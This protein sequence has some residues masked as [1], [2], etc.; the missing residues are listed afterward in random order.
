MI[1]KVKKYLKVD[2]EDDDEII[3][4]LISAAKKYVTNATGRQD[5]KEPRMTLLIMVL[6]KDW[7]D[8]RYFVADKVSQRA[9]YTVNTMVH[10]LRLEGDFFE[11]Y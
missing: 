7:Y 6:V 2:Y 5:Y 8:N 10:Q 3:E 1:D 9:T 11:E 4:M